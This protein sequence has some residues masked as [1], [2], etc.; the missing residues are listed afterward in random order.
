MTASARI[1]MVSSVLSG[2]T[3]AVND[4][5]LQRLSKTLHAWT[6]KHVICFWNSCYSVFMGSWSFL[7][8]HARVLLCVAADPGARLRDI[9]A[10]VGITERRAHAIITDLVDAGYVI[11][12]R[13][14]R[15]NQYRIQTD[16]PLRD[17]T[18]RQRTIGELL[19]LLVGTDEHR[20]GISLGGR[21]PLSKAATRR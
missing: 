13:N 15:R 19:D 11:K 7:T 5:Q 18:N 8:N 9:A 17:P 6:S 16:L 10:T 2:W 4:S 21:R 14:G 12:D 20:E 3:L 1:S